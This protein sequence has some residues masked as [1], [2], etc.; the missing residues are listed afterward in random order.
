M[1][2]GGYGCCAWLLDGLGQSAAAHLRAHARRRVQ[3][4]Q[5]VTAVAS[6]AAGSGQSEHDQTD[7]YATQDQQQEIGE[8]PTASCHLAGSQQP[9]H[10][11][12][13]AR[14]RALPEKQMD[15]DWHGNRQQSPEQSRVQQGWHVTAVV[16]GESA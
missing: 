11:C 7:G 6:I 10:R 14:F 16:G 5:Q 15:E 1:I 4:H 2:G 9:R 8:A 13:R 3:N 12:P